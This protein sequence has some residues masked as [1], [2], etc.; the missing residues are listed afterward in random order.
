M[1]TV[2]TAEAEQNFSSLIKKVNEGNSVTILF[3]GQP[4]ANIIPAMPKFNREQ[5]FNEM[6]ELMS[7]FK[8]TGIEGWK[9][10][11]IYNERTGCE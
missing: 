4:C 9:R 2:T 5:A 1:I 6:W 8:D 3:N 10:A 11:D 7:Q